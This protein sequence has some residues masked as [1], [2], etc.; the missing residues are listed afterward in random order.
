MQQSPS[1][2]ANSSSHQLIK[3][4]PKRSRTK[5]SLPCSQYSATS[6]NHEPDEANHALPP[7]IFIPF[8]EKRNFVFIEAGFNF[9]TK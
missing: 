3:K 6:P 7:H 1:L 2:E 9:L 4:F 5:D 8:L